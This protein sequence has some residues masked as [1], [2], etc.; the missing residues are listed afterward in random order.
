M[1]HSSIEKEIITHRLYFCKRFTH[2][3]EAGKGLKLN[4]IYSKNRLALASKSK[5]KK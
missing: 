1:K 5:E 2:V 3:P 4:T